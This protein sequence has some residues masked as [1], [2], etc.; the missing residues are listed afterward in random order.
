MQAGQ[1]NSGSLICGLSTENGPHR[2]TSPAAHRL[3]PSCH[4]FAEGWHSDRT[5]SVCTSSGASF[6]SS[7]APAAPAPAR[8]IRTLCIACR[9]T[10]DHDTVSDVWLS[11][12]HRSGTCEGIGGPLTLGG[13]RTG[14]APGALR[15]VVQVHMTGDDW[16]SL[17]AQQLTSL[18]C[19]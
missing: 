5:Y 2:Y 8:P 19:C 7:S 10:P 6:S 11:G 18:T 15:H 12:R 4:R 3:S 9:L 13:P 16:Q 17:P 14:A 1:T